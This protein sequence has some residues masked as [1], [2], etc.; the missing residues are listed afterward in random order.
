MDRQQNTISIDSVSGKGT[1]N[2]VG[3]KD[4]NRGVKITLGKIG[5]GS[6]LNLVGLEVKSTTRI[7]PPIPP[8]INVGEIDGNASNVR[9][10]GQKMTI[11]APS[12]PSPPPSRSS[13]PDIQVG[14]ITIHRNYS[15]NPNNLRVQ[16]D[17]INI[18]IGSKTYT[19]YAQL[20]AAFPNDK[21]WVKMARQ[22]A[23]DQAKMIAYWERR[24]AARQTHEMKEQEERE[25]RERQKEAEDEERERQQEER[26]RMRRQ[27]RSKYRHQLEQFAHLDLLR[28]TM[29]K[30]FIQDEV[31]YEEYDAFCKRLLEQKA[32]ILGRTTNFVYNKTE[33]DLNVMMGDI[34]G[35]SAVVVNE[36]KNV[37]AT[38]GDFYGEEV[39]N[40]ATIR[41]VA[42]TSPN[43]PY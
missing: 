11:A 30:K 41:L 10:I 5:G 2:I 15:S 18:R 36:G 12:S 27:E 20:A 19:S 21:T 9:I 4:P 38:M 28:K 39:N 37:D 33:G 26:E 13:S 17:E 40:V 24:K 8:V 29:E 3:S 31:T 14:G 22:E 16:P 32:E 34:V 23:Q 7:T 6:T 42:H 1:T 35:G 43:Q 25:E